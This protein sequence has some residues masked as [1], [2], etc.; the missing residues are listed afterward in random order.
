MFI[1]Y[2]FSSSVPPIIKDALDETIAVGLGQ[3]IIIH[4]RAS[5]FPPPQISWQKD[6][7]DI[8]KNSL[9]M[10]VMS[11]GSLVINSTRVGDS[12]QY[13]CLANNVAGFQ[14]RQ[15]T[16]KV[17]GKRGNLSQNLLKSE[18]SC[19]ISYWPLARTSHGAIVPCSP[20]WVVNR[21]MCK[22]CIA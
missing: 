17:Q 6:F 20:F 18:H 11:D 8:P 19:W 1:V 9:A 7:R 21:F 5:G 2:F 4:C 15:V 13:A 3:S 12:G 16:L 22:R 10:R 14:T